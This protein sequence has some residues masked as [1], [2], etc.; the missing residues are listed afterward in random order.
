MPEIA[1]NVVVDLASGRVSVDGQEFPW[2][3]SADETLDVVNI[4][5]NDFPV[6][7]LPVLASSVTVLPRKE[8]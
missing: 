8:G 7:H 5:E 3:L 2:Y 6:V 4:G 1:K